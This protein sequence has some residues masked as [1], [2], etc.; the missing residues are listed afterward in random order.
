MESARN[1]WTDICLK[2]QIAPDQQVKDM[3]MEERVRIEGRQAVTQYEQ[4]CRT[5]QAQLEQLGEELSGK[6]LPELSGL[7]QKKE[8]LRVQ[9][10][11]ADEKVGVLQEQLRRLDKESA[12]L[13]QLEKKLGELDEQYI[14]CL[15]YTSR[16]G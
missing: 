11:E 8:D 16:C 9:K 6:T 12:E 3:L 14:S 10:T 5:V 7:Q 2:E 1:R 15:L 13:G 4:D